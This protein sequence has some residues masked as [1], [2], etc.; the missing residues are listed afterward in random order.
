VETIDVAV[1]GGGVIGLAIAR[2]IAATHATVCVLER[3]PKPGME[4][5]T[6]NS[7]VIHAGIYYPAGSLKAKLCIEGAAAL[8]AYCEARGVPHARIG[9]LI[10]AEPSQE[11]ELSELLSRGQANGSCNLRLVD[12]AFTRAREP[13]IRAL[14]ALFSPDT[15]IVEAEAL[16]RTLAA[17]CA[18]R[19]VSMLPGTKLQG[20]DAHRGEFELVTSRERFRA[21]I[22]VNAAGLFADEVSQ[23]LGGDSFRIHPARGEYAELTR[24]TRGLVRGLVYP[25]PGAAGH[26]GL[27]FTRTTRGDVWLGPTSRFQSGKEDYEQDRTPVEEFLHHAQ[28]LIPSLTLDDLRLSGSGIRAKLHPAG[29]SFADFMIRHDSSQPNVIQVAGIDSPGLTSCLAI[30]EMAA[31]LAA[32]A[33]H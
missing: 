10:V 32:D 24:A 25:L 6:H 13:H 18:D 29:E 9:K 20:A 16:V 12:A 7:G 28:H 21:R 17:D 3:H 23:M 27:H 22:V 31:Q 19:D 26:L 8:Y 30:G 4:S 15:G 5:S 14:P 33:L 1:I 11:R 2:A